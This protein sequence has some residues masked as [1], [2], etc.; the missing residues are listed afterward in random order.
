MRETAETINKYA[1]QDLVSPIPNGGACGRQHARGAL[2][3]SIVKIEK[4]LEALRTLERAIPWNLLN[5]E[6]E[7]SL[8]LHFI[9]GL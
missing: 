8:W 3:S 1:S 4:E 9:R 5:A 2:K 6:D 7:A